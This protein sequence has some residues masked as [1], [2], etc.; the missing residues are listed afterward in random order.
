[1]TSEVRDNVAAS[2]YELLVDG[3][4]AG[5]ADYVEQGDALVFPHTVIDPR[6]R[7]RGYGAILVRGALDDVRRR[8]HTVIPRCWFVA[9]FIRAHGEYASMVEPSAQA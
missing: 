6:H 5:T 1:V 4:I 7:G 3:A 8:G 2:R 9:E